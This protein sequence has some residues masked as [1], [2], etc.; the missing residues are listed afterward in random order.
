MI[1]HDDYGPI[2]VLVLSQELEPLLSRPGV[3]CGI[4]YVVEFAFGGDATDQ[5]DSLAS[6]GWHRVVELLLTW[7][8]DLPWPVPLLEGGLVHVDY[9]PVLEK[10]VGEL[11]YELLPFCLQGFCTPMWLELVAGAQVLDAVFQVQLT[12]ELSTG[13]NFHLLCI[14]AQF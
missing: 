4:N 6:C 9:Q 2:E 13:I 14:E 11:D 5:C 8:E 3:R 1:V 10:D 12:Q 7:T